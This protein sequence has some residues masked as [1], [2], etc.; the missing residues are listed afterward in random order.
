MTPVRRK[1][2]GGAA[3]LAPVVTFL[4]LNVSGFCFSE[5]KY[6]SDAEFIEQ[7]LIYRA[8]SI[9]DL[10]GDNSRD[11]IAEYLRNNPRCCRIEDSSFPLSSS[12][13]DRIFGLKSTWVRI[14]HRLPDEKAAISPADGAYYEA[15]VQLDCCG[16]PV[17]V[18]GLRVTETHA[19]SL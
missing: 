11:A 14:I 6:V 8:G 10:A 5:T 9:K 13:I 1:L 15:Y 12:F 18:T 2:I 7:A 3:V 16:R 19:K 17:R 4:L